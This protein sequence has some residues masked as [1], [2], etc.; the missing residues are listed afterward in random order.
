LLLVEISLIEFNSFHRRAQFNEH[1]IQLQELHK[2]F[3]H[4]LFQL[5][6][7]QLVAEALVQDLLLIATVTF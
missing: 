3:C 6:P 1:Q 7:D 4:Q 5:A 2:E